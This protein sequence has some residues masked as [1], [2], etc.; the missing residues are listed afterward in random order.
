MRIGLSEELEGKSQ[1][2]VAGEN[3][4]RFI[5]TSMQ[6]RSTAARIAVVERGQ[7]IVDEAVAVHHLDRSRDTQRTGSLYSKKIGA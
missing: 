7:I 3:G 4:G 5:K 6:G 1:Q 2:R